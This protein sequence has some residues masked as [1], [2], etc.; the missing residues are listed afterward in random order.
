MRDLGVGIGL[1]LVIEGVLWAAFPGLAH[2]LA[3]L[4]S[5]TPESALSMAGMVAMAAGVLVVW[6]ARR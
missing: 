1:F 6:L 5:E 2:R 4:A 3:R